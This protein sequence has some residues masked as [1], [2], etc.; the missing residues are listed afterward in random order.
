MKSCCQEE[1]ICQIPVVLWK[2]HFLSP[3]IGD[4]V[5]FVLKKEGYLP[6]YGDENE[7]HRQ[8][9]VFFA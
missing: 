7:S 6:L 2:Y 3:Q 8:N 9:R 5:G 1:G 4:D